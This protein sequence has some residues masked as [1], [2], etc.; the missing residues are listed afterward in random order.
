MACPSTTSANVEF[1]YGQVS[2]ELCCTL[3][4][5]AV[6]AMPSCLVVACTAVSRR[7]LVMSLQSVMPCVWGHNNAIRYTFQ[8]SSCSVL[9]ALPCLWPRCGLT[10]PQS[11]SVRPIRLSPPHR[12]PLAGFWLTT[13]CR[14]SAPFSLHVPF[15]LQGFSSARRAPRSY[16]ALSPS[17]SRF[18][19][20]ILSSP[21][22]VHPPFPGFPKSRIHPSPL[23]LDALA[24]T[25]AHQRTSCPVFH[26]RV[27]PALAIVRVRV[28]SP[29]PWPLTTFVLPPPLLCTSVQ[30]PC[31]TACP[32]FLWPI[33]TRAPASC[34]FVAGAP[35]FGKA[36][37]GTLSPLPPPPL[38][39][40][41]RMPVHA[42]LPTPRAR[43]LG[44]EDVHVGAG[45]VVRQVMCM[46]VLCCDAPARTRMGRTR[47]APE[48]FSSP[49]RPPHTHS[50]ART[51]R[52]TTCVV[53]VCVSLSL[54]LRASV[55]VRCFWLCVFPALRV[56]LSLCGVRRLGPQLKAVDM[57][58]SPTSTSLCLSSSPS[59]VFLSPPSVPPPLSLCLWA[60]L[61][62]FL[63][64]SR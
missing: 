60:C 17:S 16:A 47:C 54:A 63:S 45:Q 48:C 38:T 29:L 62:L 55:C 34:V 26:R 32:H 8:N 53:R 61:L 46:F 51:A 49:R 59:L 58:S 2:V 14:S 25:A 5:I 13:R 41:V 22:C 9:A 21:L 1:G 40:F 10:P 24:A 6:C 3:P 33:A 43:R 18:R 64:S 19:R 11:H 12:S 35:A 37:V 44:K 30:S 23:P 28:A 4:G 27:P 42:L 20:P 57:D 15:S 31:V 52:R 36:V 7:G 56:F 50:S 39:P